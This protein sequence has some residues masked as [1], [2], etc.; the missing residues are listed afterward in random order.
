MVGTFKRSTVTVPKILVAYVSGSKNVSQ[1]NPFIN[2]V[3]ISER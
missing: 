1:E 2:A 3:E